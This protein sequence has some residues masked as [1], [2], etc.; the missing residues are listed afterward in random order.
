MSYNGWSNY[1]TWCV[2]LW[3]D[4]EPGT[5]EERCDIMRD[6]WS[7]TDEDDEALTRSEQARDVLAQWLKAFVEE[8]APSLD[9]SLYGDL[10]NA[11]LSEVNWHE[12]AGNWL[13]EVDGY[14]SAA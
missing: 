4:N 9:A 8:S 11:A 12:I 6:A 2:A 1:E 14:E 3:M 13:T 7:N 5:Y 10:L